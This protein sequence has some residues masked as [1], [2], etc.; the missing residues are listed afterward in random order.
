MIDIETL[1]GVASEMLKDMTNE[2]LD[3]RFRSNEERAY[4]N[5][6]ISMLT[7]MINEIDNH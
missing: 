6:Q 4:H 1:R 5:G 3:C 2:Q 7:W